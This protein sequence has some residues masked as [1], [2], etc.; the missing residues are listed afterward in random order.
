MAPMA[1]VS[2]IDRDLAGAF[3]ESTEKKLKGN[4]TG[5]AFVL[6]HEPLW[7]EEGCRHA[8][9]WHYWTVPNVILAAL[10][11]SETVSH[12]TN[13]VLVGRLEN[14]LQYFHAQLANGMSEKAMNL[15]KNR[16]VTGLWGVLRNGVM[17]TPTPTVMGS[18]SSHAPRLEDDIAD[19]MRRDLEEH[20]KIFYVIELSSVDFGGGWPHLEI[21]EQ[22]PLDAERLRKI[23]AAAS[24]LLTCL[25]SIGRDSSKLYF[26]FVY[27]YRGNGCHPEEI[28][29]NWS[30]IIDYV[31]AK[32]TDSGAPYLHVLDPVNGLPLEWCE[33]FQDKIANFKH[34]MKNGD[35]SCSTA[36]VDCFLN[37]ET[38]MR[39][40]YDKG[41]GI[42]PD[43]QRRLMKKALGSKRELSTAFEQYTQRFTPARFTTF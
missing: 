11:G 31:Q 3:R 17:P 29:K 20:D 5:P 18:S 33:G 19:H 23:Y 22:Q 32:T 2:E 27:R 16:S 42:D 37:M 28:I 21:R 41:K 6:V 43:D 25:E 26:L 40:G 39:S 34:H 9:K 24:S 1:V 4:R 7:H 14:I 35:F 13:R 36:E 38:V 10:R 30:N 8:H 15:M 12:K